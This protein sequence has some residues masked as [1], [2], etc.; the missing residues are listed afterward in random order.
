MNNDHNFL[1]AAIY[2]AF[3][4]ERVYSGT[5]IFDFQFLILIL[6][7]FYRLQRPHTNASN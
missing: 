4:L 3:G 1:V 2:F 5:S 6:N 7:E